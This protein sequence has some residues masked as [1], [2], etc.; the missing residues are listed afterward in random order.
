M[1][2]AFASFIADVKMPAS[3]APSESAQ[4]TRRDVPRLNSL[5]NIEIRA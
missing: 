1:K 2:S 4:E 3:L 5:G